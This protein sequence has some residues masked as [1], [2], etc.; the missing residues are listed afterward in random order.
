MAERDLF[1]GLLISSLKSRCPGG[2]CASSPKA[3]FN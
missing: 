2:A 3:I 1:E